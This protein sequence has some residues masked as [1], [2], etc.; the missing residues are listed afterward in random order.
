MYFVRGRGRV[1]VGAVA[2]PR[3]S[4]GSVGRRVGETTCLR[5]AGVAGVQW[6]VINFFARYLSG[7]DSSL[8]GRL[9]WR[10]RSRTTKRHAATLANLLEHAVR[11]VSIKPIAAPGRRIVNGVDHI[12]IRVAHVRGQSAE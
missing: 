11:R 12:R 6:I 8:I 10:H 9:T 7:G 2:C 5:T 4:T 3:F 1:E